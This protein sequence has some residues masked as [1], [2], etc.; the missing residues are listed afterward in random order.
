MMAERR[1][2]HH[3]DL[4]AALTRLAGERIAE[5]GVETISVRALAR[6]AGVAH[7][8]AYQHF[9]DKDALVAAVLTQG[10]E[11]LEEKLSAAA[12]SAKAPDK[13]LIAIA[14]AYAAFAFAEPNMFLAM[15]GPR[16]NQAGQFPD[17]EAALRRNWRLITEPVGAGVDSGVFGIGDTH[18]AAA[19][20]WGG[21]QGVIAQA[22]LKRIKLKAAEREA[23]F[24]TV[25]ERLVASLKS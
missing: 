20:Y 17:L 2:Y 21:L 14:C 8:A 25:A 10:Y 3:G 4:R 24:Q 9:P 16:L 22:V 7:R 19:I 6:E 15:T 1:A 18:A 12:G 11:R 23:F 5:S 13:K